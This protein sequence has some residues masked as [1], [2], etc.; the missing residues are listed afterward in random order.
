MGLSLGDIALDALQE[1]TGQQAAPVANI[2]EFI[3]SSW[4]LR[5]RLYPVQR[6]I[7]K[8]HYGIPLDDGPEN[9]TE[10][11]LATLP[12]LR[13]EMMAKVENPRLRYKGCAPHDRSPGL[14]KQPEHKRKPLAVVTSTS[15]SCT[16]YPSGSWYWI[17]Y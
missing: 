15:R 12:T 9:L 10:S 13:L 2:I 11:V 17:H 4:G 8:A 14:L 1:A 5:M 16:V 3:E 6:L 7:L